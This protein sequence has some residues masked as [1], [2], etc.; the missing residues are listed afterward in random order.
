MT[1]PRTVNSTF[2]AEKFLDN[3]LVIK[4]L[5]AL[6]S[7]RGITNIQA[8]HN[9]LYVEY[10]DRMLDESYIKSTLENLNFPFE[11]T[12]VQKGFF[13]RMIDKIADDNKTEFGSSGPHC[14]G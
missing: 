10:Y 6:N 2:T 8:S 9:Q 13:G 3:E 12:D 7:I 14:C 1:Q 11:K 5:K 4:L